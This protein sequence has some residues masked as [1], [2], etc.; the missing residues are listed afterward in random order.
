MPGRSLKRLEKPSQELRDHMT[1]LELLFSALGEEITRSLAIKEDAKGF[2]ENHEIAQ[3]GGREA[4]KARQNLEKN[5]GL[6]VVS[7]DSFLQLK[8]GNAN[9]LP[10]ETTGSEKEAN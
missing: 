4:G 9:E 3:K 6:K 10:P 8:A 5:T 7:T 2:N 1:N